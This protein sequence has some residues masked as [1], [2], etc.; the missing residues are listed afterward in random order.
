MVASSTKNQT[1]KDERSYVD[2][3]KNSPWVVLDDFGCDVTL[4][5]SAVGIVM[6]TVPDVLYVCRMCSHLPNADWL[7]DL[8]QSTMT[9]LR[10]RPFNS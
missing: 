3:I 4:P 6:Y 5:A 9:L 7:W 2:S 10:G 8:F 1:L